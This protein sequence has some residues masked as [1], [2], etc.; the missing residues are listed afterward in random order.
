MKMIIAG[1]MIG[2]KG[3]DTVNDEHD[4]AGSSVCAISSSPFSCV[5][6]DFYVFSEGVCWLV[7]ILHSCIAF[8]VVQN[9][10]A[11]TM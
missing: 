1:M 11:S 5:V 3:N 10:S 9:L 6:L 7:S 8:V 4:G 2:V